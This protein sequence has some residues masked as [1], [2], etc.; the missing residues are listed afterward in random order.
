VFEIS[1]KWKVGL[2]ARL[3]ARLVGW[4]HGEFTGWRRGDVDLRLL[5][6]EIVLG[7]A[8]SGFSARPPIFSAL[9]SQQGG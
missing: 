7:E 4:L 6:W 1:P 5:L 2:V 3:V 9:A 8:E